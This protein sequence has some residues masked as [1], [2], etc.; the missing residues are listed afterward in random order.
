MKCLIKSIIKSFVKSMIPQREIIRINA[1]RNNC[2]F[3]KRPL[4]NTI[5]KSKIILPDENNER[6]LDY[7]IQFSKIAEKMRVDSTT[8][9]IYP[10]DVYTVRVLPEGVVQ[11][12]SMT[13]DFGKVI[14]SSLL[15]LFENKIVNSKNKVFREAESLIVSGILRL[16]ERIA[17]ML[18]KRKDARSETLSDYFS[19]FLNRDAQSFDEAIQKL[20][21]Y[22]GLFWQMK[23][24][25]IGL[26]R[27]DLILYPYYE[28]DLRIGRISRVD[29]KEKIKEMIRMIGRDYRT[30]SDMM[31]GD[32]GQYILLGGID[33]Q[34]NIVHNDLTE[35]FLEIFSEIRIPDPKLIVRV[36]DRTSSVLW[37][38]TIDSILAGTGSPL[39]MNETVIMK[40]MVRF[41]YA[42]D[43]VWNVGTSACW[44]P[45]IIGKSFDQNNPFRS[46]SLPAALNCAFYS[47]KSFDSFNC[48]FNEFKKELKKELESVIIERDFDCS[49]LFTLFFDNCL[50]R[51]KD[52]SRGGA[53]YSNHGCQVVGLPNTVNALLNIKK[54]IFD[55]GCLTFEM[56]QKALDADFVGYEDIR[57]LLQAGFMKFGKNDAEVI[58]IT[59]EIMTYTG[60]VISAHDYEKHRLKVGFSSPNY[61]YEGKLV[62]ATMDGRK[63]KTPFAVHISPVSSGIDLA[64]ILDFATGIDYTDNRI[65]GNV[66]DF[67]IPQSYIKN[68]D[69]LIA[70]LQSACE[71]GVFELQLNVLDKCTL[72]D[73][74]I[75]PDRHTDLIVRVWGYS[76]YFNDLPEEFK[77]NLIARAQI[78]ES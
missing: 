15:E 61:I 13:V 54:Y 60:S 47:K 73:A 48:F 30:K 9:Y 56:C 65:N 26:G 59:N 35:I 31:I 45:L 53:I 19:T 72:L 40:N 21:F 50:D 18:S 29:A 25:H 43:D 16:A 75:H 38:K 27:L 5:L 7:A 55:Q 69:G 58:A 36:N 76:A 51:E 2:I 63:S 74:K 3:T 37:R 68:R 1:K 57:D 4:W 39:I 11:L 14:S 70:I 20:L 32:T 44:E 66:V 8:E 24:R 42:P 12:A 71:R 17:G 22:H 6:C 52:F 78:Y 10:Y 34:D 77:D 33:Q 23:H 67:I 49:P 41:G 28:A 62:G 46:A 64:E